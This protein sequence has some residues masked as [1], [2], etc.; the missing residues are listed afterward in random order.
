MRHAADA[1]KLVMVAA[2]DGSNEPSIAFHRKLGF[3]ETARMPGLGV[4]HGR[5]LDLVML[6]RDLSGLPE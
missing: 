6:Q 4:K 3:V 1:G 5:R 2:V